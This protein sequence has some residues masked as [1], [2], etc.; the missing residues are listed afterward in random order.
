MTHEEFEKKVMDTLLD[1]E[2]KILVQLRKQYEAAEV[3]YMAYQ[4]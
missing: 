4:L 1:G 2:D 3:G